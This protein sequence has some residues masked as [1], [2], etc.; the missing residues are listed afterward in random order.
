MPSRKEHC[1]LKVCSMESSCYL[2]TNPILQVVVETVPGGAGL[3]PYEDNWG[4]EPL[5]G[6]ED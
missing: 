5:P 3:G 4:K 2:L 1:V 6:Y